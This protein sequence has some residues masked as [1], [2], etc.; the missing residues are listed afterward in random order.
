MY[1]TVREPPR[2]RFGRAAAAAAPPLKET[3]KYLLALRAYRHFVLGSSIFTL[4]AMGSGIWIPSF[5]V[6]VHH[7]PAAQVAVWLACVYG[8]GGLLG[9]LAGGYLADRAVQRTGDMRWYAWICCIV[10]M[11]ILPFSLFVYLWPDPVQALLVQTC[12][13]FLMHAWMGPTYGTIQGLA[14]VR[15][16]AMA[17]A[18]NMLTINL[19]SYGLGPLLVGAA[20]DY[21]A[22][23]VGNESLRY[24]IL[25]VVAVSYT[26]AAVHFLLAARTLPQDLKTAE[27][28]P[29]ERSAQPC[30][31]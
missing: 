29:S 30:P 12:T 19:I 25:L 8:G 9:A 10:T 4:G 13:A 15:R 1:L 11:A 14:G 5:F 16:R 24:S 28:E 6:R 3:L 7:M 18:V 22:A 31:R 17:A 20:S 27:C 21:F 2:G 23:R 26:W